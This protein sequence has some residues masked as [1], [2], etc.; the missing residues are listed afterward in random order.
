MLSFEEQLRSFVLDNFPFGEVDDLSNEDS[1]TDRG[2]ID[3]TGVLELVSFLEDSYGITIEDR[4]L[5]P[6]NLDSINGLVKF[7]ERKLK[8]S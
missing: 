7:L 2:I 8:D 4:E 6:A 1:F 5:I 3:S